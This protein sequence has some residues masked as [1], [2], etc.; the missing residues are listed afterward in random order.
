MTM[1]WTHH[2]LTFRLL[3][4]LHVGYRRTGNLMQTRPYVPG[5]LLWA[6]LTARLTRNAGQGNDAQAYQD[7]GKAVQRHFRFGYLWPSLDG[8]HPYFPWTHKD[9]DYRLDDGVVVADDDA[10]FRWAH[11]DFDYLFLHS[12]TSTPITHTHTAEEGMLHEIEYLAPHTRNGRPVYLT[13]DVWVK[14]S[15][16]DSLA[17]WK[18]ALNHLQFG[19]ERGY[20][21]GRVKLVSCD[22]QKSNSKTIAGYPWKDADESVRITIPAN[23][24]LT[25]HALATPAPHVQGQIEPLIGWGWHNGAYGLNEAQIAFVPHA[26]TTQE[27]TFLVN[28]FGLLTSSQ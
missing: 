5:R 22:E 10:Y 1:T 16:P 15:L 14:T 2:R 27:A 3:S 17:S 6:A 11:K 25:A 19:G 12:Y 4:P 21:W 28:A 13:G 23:K 26:R 20:G 8:E 18:D 7:T 9:F 24:P